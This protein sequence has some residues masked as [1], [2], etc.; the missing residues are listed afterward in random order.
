MQGNE[1]R[2]S[3]QW[4]R[5]HLPKVCIHIYNLFIWFSYRRFT[6]WPCFCC[7]I[8]DSLSLY[9][10]FYVVTLLILMF[11]EYFPIEI[12]MSAPAKQARRFVYWLGKKTEMKPFSSSFSLIWSAVSLLSWQRVVHQCHQVPARMQGNKRLLSALWIRTHP[13][14]VCIYIYIYAIY[15]SASLPSEI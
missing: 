13:L 10:C 8:D 3:N 15:L 4:I 11:W 6:W 5:T 14:K 7:N 12:P 2:L 9:C 1:K